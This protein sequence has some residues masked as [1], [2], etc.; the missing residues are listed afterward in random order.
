MNSNIITKAHVERIFRNSTVWTETIFEKCTVVACQLP[1]GFILTESSGC[2]DKENYDKV[3]GYQIC[4]KK[5]KNE[6]W[7]LEGYKLQ[8]ELSKRNH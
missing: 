5:I 2:V 6:I 7:K 8:D 3:L 4:V 1:N